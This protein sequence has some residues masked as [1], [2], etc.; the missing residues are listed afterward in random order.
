MLSVGHI[1]FEVRTD[2]TTVQGI[3][4]RKITFVRSIYAQLSGGKK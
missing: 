4:D 1:E 3:F 2:R